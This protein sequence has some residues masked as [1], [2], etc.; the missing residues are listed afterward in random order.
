MN[1]FTWKEETI[2]ALYDLGGIAHIKE[3]Y[4]RIIERNNLDLSNAKTPKRTLSR[5]LQ[6]HSFSTTYGTEN[7]F[8][9]VYGV[10]SKKGIWGLVDY[11]LDNMGYN[12]SMDDNSFS[13]GH[14][15]L[16][17]HIIRERNPELIRKAKEKFKL[18]HNGKLYCEIC[19]FDF[20]KKYGELG[21]DFIEAHHIKPISKMKDGEKTNIND[22]VMLCS[23]CHSMI[24]RKKPW[25]SKD[26]LSEL[27]KNN[28]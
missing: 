25:L 26:R 23:N 20:F 11:T 22:I 15:N 28:L 8:Y 9:C 17:Q 3:I 7:I 10:K 6:S 1:S 14:V 16:R 21:K 2:E 12:L 24:H 4:N 13:E 19:K 18:E 27:L 5:V